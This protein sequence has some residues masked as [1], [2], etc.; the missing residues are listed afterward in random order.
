MCI[1]DRV[2]DDILSEEG[3]EKILGKPVGNDKK[4]KKCTYRFPK[5]TVPR[6]ESLFSIYL[7]IFNCFNS[8]NIILLPRIISS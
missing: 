3:N 4:L 1:R 2:K 8:S 7:I 5:K 6:Q